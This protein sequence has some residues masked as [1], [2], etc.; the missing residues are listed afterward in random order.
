[1][2]SS[3]MARTIRS[4]CLLSLAL[5]TPIAIIE[6]RGTP[7]VVR[8]DTDLKIPMRD[9]VMLAADLY[10]PAGPRPFPVLLSRTPYNKSRVAE[11]AEQFVGHGYAVVAVDSRGLNASEGEWSP[12]VDEAKDGYDTQ[13]WVDNQPRCN[14]KIGMFGSS[15]PGFTQL[16]PARFLASVCEGSYTNLGSVRQ[17]W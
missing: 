6:L 2:P 8:K 14:G 17:L 4:I 3:F 13:V 11:Q 12:Y 1:M 9:R 5:Y 10:R 15:Y 16:L 7:E